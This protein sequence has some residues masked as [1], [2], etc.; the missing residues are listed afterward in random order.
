MCGQ[1]SIPD[2]LLDEGRGMAEALADDLIVAGFEVDRMIDQTVCPNKEISSPGLTYH[3]LQSATEERILFDRLAANADR[4]LLIA[5]ETDGSLAERVRWTIQAKGRLLGPSINIVELTADKHRL[6][7]HLA[8]AGIPVPV[9]MALAAGSQLP[10]DFPYPAVLKPR[11]GAGSQETTLVHQVDAGRPVPF[12]ARLE[13]Y[14]VGQTI[15]VAV[16]GGPEGIAALPAC[17]QLLSQDGTFTYLGGSLP[18]TEELASR[19]QELAVRAATACGE[20]CGYMG[21]DLILGNHSEED[22]VIEINPRL[23]TSY[24]LLRQAAQENL[25]ETI[26]R[27]SLEHCPPP[28]FSL[29]PADFS[30]S[31]LREVMA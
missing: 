21:V 2:S 8:A 22:C 30:L 9:G 18:L 4:T 11:D 28:S 24:L 3:R 27:W 29:A 7:V 5:P 25:A 31:S 10:A 20:F 6:A 1:P 19:G 26:V 15:S 13:K 12:E 16:L 23:T 17:N 14:V